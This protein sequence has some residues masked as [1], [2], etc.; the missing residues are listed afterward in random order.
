MEFLSIVAPFYFMIF[1][2]LTTDG[3]LRGSGAMKYFMVSTF[4]DLILRVV[5]AYILVLPFEATGI[6][7]PW[8]IGWGIGTVLCMGFYKKGVWRV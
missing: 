3:V 1:M 4:G 2:K 5:L 8:P 6:W 7:L